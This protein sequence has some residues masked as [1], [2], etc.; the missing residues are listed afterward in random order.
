MDTTKSRGI[1]GFFE[2]RVLKRVLLVSD[3]RDEDFDTSN[4]GKLLRIVEKW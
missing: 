2:G 4:E 1:L 3:G